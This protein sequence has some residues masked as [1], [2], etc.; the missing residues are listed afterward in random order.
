MLWVIKSWTW[1]RWIINYDRHLM[2]LWKCIRINDFMLII[3]VILISEVLKIASLSY[4][5]NC[6][7]FSLIH[8]DRAFY[9]GAYDNTGDR[10]L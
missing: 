5:L 3:K 9:T 1:E 8:D 4:C 2:V 6:V 7:L 10:V